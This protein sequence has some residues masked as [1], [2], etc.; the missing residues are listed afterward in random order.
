VEAQYERRAYSALTEQYEREALVLQAHTAQRLE[1]HWRKYEAGLW[2]VKLDTGATL[3]QS[4]ITTIPTVA[5][6]TLCYRL[7]SINL[8]NWS[9]S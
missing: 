4:W 3:R 5:G 8:F 6:G 9:S 7:L 1:N 2:Q